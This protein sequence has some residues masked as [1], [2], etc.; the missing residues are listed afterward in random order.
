M[1][2][3]CTWPKVATD[4]VSVFLAN[5][6]DKT[7]LHVLNPAAS[8]RHTSHTRC[9]FFPLSLLVLLP[10][11]LSCHW[12]VVI[13]LILSVDHLSCPVS[14]PFSL[15]PFLACSLSL[16][17]CLPWCTLPTVVKIKLL[18]Y[19][20]IGLREKLLVYFANSCKRKAIGVLC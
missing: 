16:L 6:G 10:P 4:V 2:C 17:P 19:F 11:F 20:A 8:A 5:D 15:S 3:Q 14:L 12:H 9:C 7:L 13:F 1:W 18:V